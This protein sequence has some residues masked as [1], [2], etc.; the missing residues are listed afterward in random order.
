MGTHLWDMGGDIKLLAQYYL[1]HSKHHH[2][3]V[4]IVTDPNNCNNYK[5]L[6]RFL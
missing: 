1:E 5:K 6:H 4:N 2:L 3:V